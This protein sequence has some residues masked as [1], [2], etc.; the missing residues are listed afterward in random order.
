MTEPI[1]TL[2]LSSIIEIEGLQDRPLNANHVASLVATNE[3]DRWPPIIVTPMGDK[4]G[5]IT[6]KHR[7]A[8][9]KQL[10]RQDIRA[11]VRTYVNKAEMYCAMWEDNIKNGLP[12]STKERKAY[13]VNLY[14]MQPRM[15]FRE[16][17]RRAGLD[18]QTVQAAIQEA[19]ETD[20][21]E[22]RAEVRKMI[23]TCNRIVKSCDSFLDLT[24]NLSAKDSAQVL[25]EACS[26]EGLENLESIFDDMLLVFSSALKI[27][28]QRNAGI[29]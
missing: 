17:G 21:N 18:H 26:D 16:I 29:E 6:G 19:Q 8:A 24:E 4:Y 7:I 3:P 28:Q 27:V 25:I 20:G 1:I 15:S 10:Q 11:V 13:A 14:K 23:S 5:R 12:P 9:L 22:N 2:P